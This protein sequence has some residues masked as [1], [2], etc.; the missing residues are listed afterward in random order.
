MVPHNTRLRYGLLERR[1]RCNH[2]HD[3]RVCA[4]FDVPQFEVKSFPKFI[5]STSFL[6]AI[7]I[8]VRAV[9]RGSLLCCIAMRA[10]IQPS[11]SLYASQILPIMQS[12]KSVWR[13]LAVLLP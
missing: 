12:M 3:V 5:G 6:F 1:W 13:R 7:H 10:R 2:A 4:Q 8:V 9:L 11:L